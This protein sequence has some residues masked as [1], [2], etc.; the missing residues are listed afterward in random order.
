MSLILVY[1]ALHL[2]FMVAWFAGIFYLP[3]LFVYHAL[4]E[5]KSC[6]S[7]LKVMERRLLLFVTPFAILTAVFGVLMIV[8]YGREWFRA[9]MWLHYKLTLVLILYAYHGYC[10][11][12]L[13]DFKHDKNTRSDRFYRIFNELP[14]LVL[15]AIIFLAVLKPAL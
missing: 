14:V 6:S 10:F 2:F 5:E 4:N 13:S 8:E 11:K 12:L 9:S 7:M 1:K 15:L 3:R